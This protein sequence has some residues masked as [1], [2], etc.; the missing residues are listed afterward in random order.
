MTLAELHSKAMN[1]MAGYFS[2]HGQLPLIFLMLDSREQMHLIP[3]PEYPAKRAFY[4]ALMRAYCFKYKISAYAFA[5]EA[6]GSDSYNKD[7]DLVNGVPHFRGPPPSQRPDRHEILM[8]G[9]VSRDEIMSEHYTI[10]RDPDGTPGIGPLR[11]YGRPVEIAREGVCGFLEGID[12]VPP[13]MAPCICEIVTATEKHGYF[14]KRKILK[15]IEYDRT[16]N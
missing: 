1:V 2:E 5:S 10:L 11:T 6:W 12:R 14:A 16:R 13:D 4:E 3:L 8:T 15:P 9:A 7:F